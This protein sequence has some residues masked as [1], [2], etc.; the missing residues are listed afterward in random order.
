[1]DTPK[2]I[3]ELILYRHTAGKSSRAIAAIVNK[4]QRTVVDIVHKFQATRSYDTSRQGRC[5]RRQKLPDHTQRL[6]ARASTINPRL[7]ARQIQGEV[8]GESS[9]VHV[10]TSKRILIR[11]GKIPYRP[12]KA[13]TLSLS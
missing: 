5:G 3:R 7:S 8:A 1:M 6:I 13:P 2:A 10:N 12:I 11:K 9:S 4:P